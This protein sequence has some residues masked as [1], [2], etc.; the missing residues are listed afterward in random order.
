MD[1]SENGFLDNRLTLRQPMN[2]YRAG[3]DAVLLAASVPVSSGETV[4]DMGCGIGTIAL[5]LA[6]RV[7]E[8]SVTGI[9]IQG[10][11]A[12]LARE[13][14]AGNRLDDQVFIREGDLGGVPDD[15]TGQAYDHVVT[16]PPYYRPE[17]SRASPVEG[18]ARSHMEGDVALDDWVGQ[19]LAL[20]KPGGTLTLIHRMERLGDIVLAAGG[21]GEMTLFPL[22]PRAGEPARQ[23]IVQVTKGKEPAI[24]L[25]PGLVMHE[26]DGTFT[27]AAD[28]VLRGRSAL[29]LALQA[30]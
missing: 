1:I 9:E 8:I 10:E 11:L 15:L 20:V 19:C 2:G 5:C 12:A 30:E 23:V 4:L 29:A 21:Q 28:D 22:W 7:P 18:K 25:T 13:N 6:S 16:N 3:S 24:H 17:Q 26:A 14:V 27:K